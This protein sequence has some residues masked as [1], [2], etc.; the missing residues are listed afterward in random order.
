[1]NFWQGSVAESARKHAT[2]LIKKL[3][4]NE[5]LYQSQFQRIVIEIGKGIGEKISF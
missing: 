5:H 3:D 1:M 2:S 4:K